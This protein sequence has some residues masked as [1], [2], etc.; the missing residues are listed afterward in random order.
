MTAPLTFSARLALRNELWWTP[1]RWRGKRSWLD[2]L[3]RVREWQAFRT[4]DDPHAAW[5]CCPYWPRLLVNK[6]NGR[7]F[8]SKYGCDV[9]ALYWRGSSAA[10]VPLESMPSHF[11]LRPVFGANLSGVRLV[12]DGR[13]LIW[14]EP[15]TAADLRS[16][17]PRARLRRGVPILIEEFVRSE[18]G[19]YRLPLELKCHTFG[20]TVAAVEVIDRLRVNRARHRYYT[21][22]WEPIADPMH[23]GLKQD[24]VIRPAPRHLDR[25]LSLA[26]ALGAA[27]G[28]YIRIDFFAADRGF[29]FNEFSTFPFSGTNY[30]PYCD[31][32]FG[33]LWAEKFP[34]A[35]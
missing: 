18:G 7:E 22:A 32:L 35:T 31:E 33:S 20:D 16:K 24:D 2:A 10:S 23:T 6:W 26:A 21:P 30:T 3:H 9:P 28:T 27:I 19:E 12:A 17:L 14:G 5:R 25:L 4:R 13:E 8:A 29:V 15:A 1:P 34:D 11:V